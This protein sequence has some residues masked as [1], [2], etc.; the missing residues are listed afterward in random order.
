MRGLPRALIVRAMSDSDG[1][2][3]DED[4]EPT[5]EECQEPEESEQLNE[6]PADSFTM[7]DELQEAFT[8]APIARVMDADGMPTPIVDDTLLD[9]HS[10]PFLPEENQICHE[11]SEEFVIRDDDWR[12]LARW[13][14]K[15]V[16]RLPSG[17]YLAPIQEALLVDSWLGEQKQNNPAMDWGELFILLTNVAGPVGGQHR[18]ATLEVAVEPLRPKCEHLLLQ[19]IP[20]PKSQAH[21]LKQGMMHRYCMA[22]RSV[23]GAFLSLTEREL[24]A[25]SLRDPYDAASDELLKYFDRTLA[26]KSR[27][28]TYHKMFNVKEDRESADAPLEAFEAATKAMLEQAEPKE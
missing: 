1:A 6:E 10:P 20:P 25:C 17:E 7:D 13:A 22:R 8:G 5:E 2:R 28:R 27:N 14:R 19:L 15:D 23:A 26:E 11:L 12:I 24:K 16:R 9:A 3:E 18:Q 21:I 4:C